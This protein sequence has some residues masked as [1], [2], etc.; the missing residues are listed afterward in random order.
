MVV[1]IIIL[2]V[3]SFFLVAFHIG[4]VVSW[5]CNE[6]DLSDYFDSPKASIVFFIPFIGSL[7]FLYKLAKERME[8][9]F[10]R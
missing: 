5:A 7:V 2:G 4:A 1:V 8:N 9:D 6:T 3:A 10:Q